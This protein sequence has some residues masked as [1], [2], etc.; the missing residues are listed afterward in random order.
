MDLDRFKEINDQLGH[1][2]GD[3]TLGEVVGRIK[4]DI[5]RED[6]LARYG[7]DELAMVLTET[8]RQ[9]GLMM[10]DRL[11]Q[12]VASPPFEYKDHVYQ[13]TMSFGLGE[14]KPEKH[15][16]ATPEDVIRQADQD[17]CQAK[18]AARGTSAPP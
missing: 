11:R 8:F 10:M 3:Y 6:L 4:S 12:R 13:V 9:G 17:L 7:D 14:V 5:R 2:G 15:G 16:V 1:L 18:Q